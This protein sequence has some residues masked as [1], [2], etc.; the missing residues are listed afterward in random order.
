M[1]YWDS[2]TNPCQL[3]HF[4][5]KPS[6]KTGYMCL[7]AVLAC[8]LVWVPAHGQVG[9]AECL[10]QV[11]TLYRKLNEP[12]AEGKI[13]SVSY[14]IEGR[15]R[16]SGKVMNTLSKVHLLMSRDRIHMITDEMEVYQDSRQVITVLPTSKALYVHDG[17]V[18][19]SRE[20]RTK[21]LG[22]FQDSLFTSCTV[23]GCSIRKGDDGREKRRVVLK[24][25]EKVKKIYSISIVTID[26]DTRDQAIDQVEYVFVPG[27]E[28]EWMKV[29][30]DNLDRDYKKD[31]FKEPLHSMFFDG[32]GAVLP[33][34]RS[35]AF[36]DNRGKKNR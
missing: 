23:T 9:N 1:M 31:A 33:K 20:L 17:D 7:I 21:M 13:Y 3:R 22:T 19:G 24:M 35:Y 12:P 8:M 25:G 18:E 36:T 30:V 29:S 28:Q 5:L 11:R 32:R 15:G 34:Y 2:L 4:S 16:R 6:M 27:S 14:S 10:E 26:I